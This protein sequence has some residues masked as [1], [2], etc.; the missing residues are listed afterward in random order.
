MDSLEPLNCSVAVLGATQHV[1]QSD[2]QQ[3]HRADEHH[4]GSH[5]AQFKPALG[6]GFVEQ[7]ANRGA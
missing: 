1:A 3:E 5:S 6:Q 7:V 4:G 2:N